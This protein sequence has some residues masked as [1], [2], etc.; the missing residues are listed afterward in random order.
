MFSELG[1]RIWGDGEKRRGERIGSK[2]L[3]AAGF[4]NMQGVGGIYDHRKRKDKAGN[5]G[6]PGGVL[7]R[8]SRRHAI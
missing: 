6:G 1:V 3:R 4:F 7:D 2:A 8:W 5:L